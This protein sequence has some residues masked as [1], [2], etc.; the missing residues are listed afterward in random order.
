MMLQGKNALVT[1][2]KG[3]IGTAIVEELAREGATVVCADL[4]YDP[5]EALNNQI[6]LDVGKAH[7]W[8][9]AREFINAR[10]GKIDVLVNNAGTSGRNGTLGTDD[11][12]FERILRTNLWGSWRGIKEFAQ[13]LSET[14]GSVVNIGSIYGERTAPIT[15]T[16]Q[17]SVAYQSSKAAV[18]QLTRVAAAELASSGVRVNA[19]LPGV[20]GTPLLAQL[21][22]DVRDR[23]ASTA[24]M[25]R[26]ADPQELAPMIAFLSSAHASFISGALI[27]VDG[28]Y[29]A[30]P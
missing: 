12:E 16:H 19:V 8:R 13:D 26:V 28:G 10:Y 27:P 21:P 17:C 5:D 30:A 4:K 24:G 1:G 6:H 22:E 2:A 14:Q 3:G 25:K 20:I 23:R 18:H 29:L 11:E 7:S 9:S 15:S